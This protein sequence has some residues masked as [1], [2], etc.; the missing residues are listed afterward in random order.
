VALAGSG[1]DCVDKTQASSELSGS[2]DMAAT[3]SA[4]EQ[5]SLTAEVAAGGGQST[6]QDD[7]ATGGSGEVSSDQ[8]QAGSSEVIIEEPASDTNVYG[9]SGTE[10][11]PAY[12]Q[13]VVIEK[14]KDADDKADMRGLT[15]GLQGGVEGYTGQLAPV[16]RPGPT[17]G[18]TA[19]LRP[20]KVLG[21]ELA[22]SGAAN[23]FR[24]SGDTDGA[25]LV[26]NGGRA[27]VTLGLGAA[28]VQ[29]YLLGGVGIDR[30]NVRGDRAGFRDDTSG[31]VPV[32]AGLRTHIGNF[33][34]DAR[35]NYNVL[36]NEDWAGGTADR[37]ILGVE[38]SRAGSYQGTI[39]LGSTF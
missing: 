22:Y 34:A 32:G 28:P 7:L 13:P 33:T 11:Q 19:N 20:S 21:L 38:T 2:S 37:D 16:I 26:R 35:L 15:V 30:L 10:P 29:P 39:Q 4:T 24:T 25:D 5:D 23:E 36:F 17:Y 18:V 31:S 1:K 3:S 6:T 8:S 12:A 27:L 14:E 9:G